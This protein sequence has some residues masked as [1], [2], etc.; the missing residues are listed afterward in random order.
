MNACYNDI[1]LVGG[2]RIP[3]A[4]KNR[5]V[6]LHFP[7]KQAGGSLLNSTQAKG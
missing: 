7:F 6:S 3:S 1:R 5:Q 4:S 2:L